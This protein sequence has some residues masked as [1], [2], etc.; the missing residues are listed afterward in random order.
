MFFF[1]IHALFFVVFGMCFSY[2]FVFT[3]ELMV[4]VQIIS[5]SLLCV[6][7]RQPGPL[8]PPPPPHLHPA[9]SVGEAVGRASKQNPGFGAAGHAHQL[10]HEASVEALQR[11]SSESRERR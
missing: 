8:P 10:P 4:F 1:E 5:F 2:V 3:Y 7:V 9:Q 11:S 6:E